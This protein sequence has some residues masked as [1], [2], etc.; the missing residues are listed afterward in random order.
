QAVAIREQWPDLFKTRKLIIPERVVDG[1][2]LIW[3]SDLVI[4][5]GGT[6]N[7]EAAALGVPVYSIFKGKPAAIDQYLASSGRLILID[8]PA[9]VECLKLV[10]RDTSVDPG[11]TEQAALGCVVENIIATLE[12]RPATNSNVSLGGRPVFG[13]R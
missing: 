4:S 7:R 8:G 13:R 10:R 2:N 12:R 11:L 5:A 6:M 9:D 1:L 3:F